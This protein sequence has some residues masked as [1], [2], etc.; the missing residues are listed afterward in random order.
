[1]GKTISKWQANCLSNVFERKV[2]GKRNTQR[3][4]ICGFYLNGKCN[5]GNDC[6][7]LHICKEFLINFNKCPSIICKNG[8]SHDPF[9]ENNAKITKSKWTETD[10]SKI[11][12]FLRESFPR[13]C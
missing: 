7:R 11:I 2:S 3:P 4:H 10:A 6:N 8:F 1:M 12:H 13:L 5:N 9:D